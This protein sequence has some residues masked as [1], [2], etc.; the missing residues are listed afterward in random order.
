MATFFRFNRGHQFASSALRDPISKRFAAVLESFAKQEQVPIIQFRFRDGECKDDMP[1]NS[2]KKF[3]KPEG[4]VFIGKAQKKASVLRTE[5]RPNEQAGA[6]YPWIL[7]STAM[8]NL[9]MG[10]V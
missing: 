10:Q 4:A 3:T 2:C 7:R 6:T 5:R 9:G 8:V 1:P